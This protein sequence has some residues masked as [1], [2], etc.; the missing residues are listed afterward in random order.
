[1]RPKLVLHPP[2]GRDRHSLD[3]AAPAGVSGADN[4]LPSIADQNWRT[5]GDAHADRDGWIIADGRVRFGPRSGREVTTGRDSD[6]GSMHLTK[7]QNPIEGNAYSP[8]HAGPLVARVTELE[9]CGR[10]EVVGDV[11]EGPAPQYEAPLGL[12]PLETTARLGLNH[13]DPRTRH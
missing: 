10:E 3:G 4:L 6:I 1:M 11:G 12:R 2:D 8:R 7:Q 13:D 5:I 9:I